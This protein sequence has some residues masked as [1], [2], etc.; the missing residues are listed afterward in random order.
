[1]LLS[2]SQTNFKKSDA[3][4]KEMTASKDPEILQPSSSMMI[5]TTRK[6]VGWKQVK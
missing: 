4:Q 3:S 1:M 6:L 2:K 5:I